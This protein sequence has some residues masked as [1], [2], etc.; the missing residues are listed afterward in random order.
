[1]I[2]G[3]TIAL[4]LPA[5]NEAEALQRLLNWIPDFVDEVIVVD[6]NSTD[7]TAEIAKLF[8]CTVLHEPKQG[9]GAA[10]KRGYRY[11]KQDI[12]V[13]MDADNSYP[14]DSLKANIQYLLDNNLDFVSCSRFPLKDKDSMN[15]INYVG[16]R[17]L[18]M[19]ANE[20]FGLEL[21]DITTGMWIMRAWILPACLDCPD[22][23]T[24][25]IAWKLWGA[26]W[27]DLC[28]F[29]ETHIGY[30]PRIGK[31]KQHRW[32]DGFKYLWTMLA[33]RIRT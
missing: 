30:K 10:L 9:Y 28:R 23:M 4:V 2:S 29:G 3:K 26:V 19:V 18:T 25:T 13:S 32:R 14:L 27:S 33:M 7:I 20:L 21:H 5:Y 15:P 6:N 17:F 8:H 31:V 16:N 1:M 12:I 22:D 24:F 11:V